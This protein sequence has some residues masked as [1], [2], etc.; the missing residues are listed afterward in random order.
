MSS[1]PLVPSKRNNEREVKM[2]LLKSKKGQSTTEYIVIMAIVVAIALALVWNQLRG[3]L[4]TAVNS[5]GDMVNSVAQ[6]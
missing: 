6:P 4:T 2:K 5:V 1:S 3:R